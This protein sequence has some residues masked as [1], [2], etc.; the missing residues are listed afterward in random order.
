M[1]GDFDWPSFWWSL[2][3]LFLAFMGDLAKVFHEQQRGSP[4]LTWREHAERLPG[5]VVMGTTS[6]GVAFYAHDAWGLSI[7]IGGL[8]GA[9]LGYLGIQ[10]VAGVAI[11]ILERFKLAPDK[12]KP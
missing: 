2:F 9:L 12:D 5:V 7:W 3:A 4:P 11:K 6:A 1:M 10:F 8:G